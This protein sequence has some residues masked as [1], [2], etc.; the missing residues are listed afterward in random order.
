M[1]DQMKQAKQQALSL[2]DRY[3]AAGPACA[4]WNI[5]SYRK[6][7]PQE[8]NYVDGCM[9]LAYL[10]LS[11]VLGEK[12]Y[13][14]FA[15]AYM[16]RFVQED[17]RVRT[18]AEEDRRLDD[19]N[20]AKTFFPLYELTGKPKYRKAADHIYGFLREFP[21]TREGNFWHKRVYPN[22]VWLDGL[23]MAMPFYM[24]YE[25]KYGGGKN[26][27]DIFT[28]FA[29]VRRRMRDEKTGLYYHG[30]DESRASRW[31]DPQ[32]GCSKSFW[33]RSIG[34]LAAALADTLEKTD[35]R[36]CGEGFRMLKDMLNGLVDSLLP[37]QEPGGMFY[38]VADRASDEKNY[39][40]TSGTC[41]IAYGI[42][43]GVRL[44]FL[45]ER[46]RAC[47]EKAFFGTMKRYFR[48]RNGEP[49]LG[50]ICLVGGLG[51]PDS[52]DGTPAYYY[53]EPVVESDGKGVA[54]FLL[55]FAEL[56]QM[57]GN[58]G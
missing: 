44:G 35:R 58:R 40:E 34:W 1:T 56:L 9:M 14:A 5:E 13:G 25:T 24:E 3:L 17:G 42:L 19:I 10:T 50:G 47:G 32:T 45:P 22:Q 39:P 31:S 48:V 4:P 54:P 18:I 8:W 12:K 28:Q 51:R 2:A 23:Y 52:R 16:D 33:L 29:T 27:G 43:K 15:E 55:A 11:R 26:C 38:Q 36:A 53:S 57:P 6:G 7:G 30:Y 37:Y 41:M 20:G 46:Y 21:R 49:S